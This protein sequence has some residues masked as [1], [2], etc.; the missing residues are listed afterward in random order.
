MR[1]EQEV[2]VH[3]KEDNNKLRGKDF[4]CLH[5]GNW[6]NDEVVNSFLALLNAR[7]ERFDKGGEYRVV[8]RNSASQGYVSYFAF[9]KM[10][11]PR[12]Y[13]FNSFFFERLTQR[14]VYD[15]EGVRRWLCRA[16]RDIRTIELILIPINL[17]GV[18]WIL[19]AID[20]R[21]RH[22][23][24][25]D[26]TL[27]IDRNSDHA[28]DALKLWFDDEVS[29]TAGKEYADQLKIPEWRTV[30]NPAYLPSQIDSDSC[31]LFTL[32]M[33][34]YLSRGDVPD[35]TNDDVKVL[36]LRTILYFKRGKLPE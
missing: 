22:F 25:F 5:E 7:D 6:L 2:L 14:G 19:T 30:V 29:Q 13:A 15:Y 10:P 17:R 23:L 11:P 26:S 33:A 1:S 4:A 9:F 32:Y 34:E 36:R 35:F 3:V 18:H 16:G 8:D 27:G 20:I 28:Q 21:N 12:L 31:G 24:H